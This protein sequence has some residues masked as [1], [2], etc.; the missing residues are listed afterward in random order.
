MKALAEQQAENETLR[1]EKRRSAAQEGDK[2]KLRLQQ[3]EQ[4]LQHMAREHEV[5]LL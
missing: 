2:A 5:L 1:E 4:Q 3:L